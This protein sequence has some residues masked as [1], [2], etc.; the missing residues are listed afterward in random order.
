[1]PEQSRVCGR[2][3]AGA[4]PTAHCIT[5][6]DAMMRVPPPPSFSV[7]AAMSVPPP[8][9]S[10]E[11]ESAGVPG[12][13]G[14]E[15][16]SSLPVCAEPYPCFAEMFIACFCADGQP[17]ALPC[18]MTG[19]RPSVGVFA[20]A[21]L[22]FA[23][24]EQAAST[25]EDDVWTPPVVRPRPGKRDFRSDTPPEPQNPET[26]RDV[27]G[28]KRSLCPNLPPPG[29]FSPLLAGPPPRSHPPPAC[30]AQGR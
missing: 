11:R 15:M 21:G 2:A 19:G 1:M 30:H 3:R 10:V 29:T 12:R 14:V 17:P 13:D 4:T 18:A 16:K 8:P 27:A 9:S 25:D 5:P 6:T 23:E 20:A 28:R 26:D 22:D 7:V 24:L